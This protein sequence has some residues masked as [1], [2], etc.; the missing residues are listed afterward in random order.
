MNPPDSKNRSMTPNAP[1]A[2][3]LGFTPLALVLAVGL[4]MTDHDHAAASDPVQMPGAPHL[5]PEDTLAYVRLDHADDLRTD[6]ANSSLGR[7]LS[8]EKLKPFATDIYGTASELFG[9]ISSEIGVSLD[10]L[11]SIP[12]GQIAIGLIPRPINEDLLADRQVPADETDEQKRRR[13]EQERRRNYQFA[14]VFMVDAGENVDKLLAIVDRFEQRLIAGSHI[15]RELTV[16]SVDIVRLLPKK[17]GRMEVEYFE[18]EGTVVFGFGHRTAQDVWDRWRKASDEPTM[19]DNANFGSVISRCVGAE[20]TRPQLT[21]FVD[22]YRIAE[23]GVRLSGSVTIGLMWPLFENLGLARIRGVGGSAFRG[24]DVFE[25]ITHLH[26]LIDPPR[27]GLLAVLRPGTGESAPPNWVPADVTGYSSIHW[28]FENTYT[29]FGKI[30]EN[31]QGADALKRLFEEPTK[32]RFG[33]DAREDVIK[34]LTGRVVRASWIQPPMRLNSQVQV[35]A[36]E[37]SDANA[38]KSTIAKYREHKPNAMKVET[39]GGRVV[40]FAKFNPKKFPEQFRRPEPCLF[41]LGN[42]LIQGDSREFAQRMMRAD[43]EAMPRLANVPEYDLVASELGGK[44]DG[45]DPFMVQFLRGGDFI[46]MFYEMSKS[47]DSRKFLRQAGENNVVARKMYELL[48]RNELPPYEEFE[49]YFAPSGSFAYDEPT[50]M[51]LGSFTLRADE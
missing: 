48:E 42:W 35:T 21:F 34:H 49:K 19:A 46:R 5:L 15:R 4:T 37:L 47:D 29:N 32:R 16:D 12:Q 30:L 50:G 31:F 45:E 25:D 13:L 7:M 51:H 18:H 40:Y 11:L 39:L 3:V 41:V 33:I 9:M 28:D 44:L 27:D 38:I 36:F 26:L 2:P 14:G 24:G 8:D 17:S 22:P 20:D 10:E 43:S 1:I 23:R 6:L